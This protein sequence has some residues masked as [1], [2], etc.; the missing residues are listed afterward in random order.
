MYLL[1][2]RSIFF[3]SL[4]LTCLL[5]FNIN[6]KKSKITEKSLDSFDALRGWNIIKPEE[7]ELKLSITTGFKQNS[8]CLDYDLGEKKLYVVISKGMSIT[9]PQNYAFTFYIKGISQRN[10][11]EFKLVDKNDNTYLKKLNN[12]KFKKDWE[13][14]V[15]K[16]DDISFG[17]GPNPKLK[18]K[19]IKRIEFAISYK[20]GVKGKIYFDELSLVHLPPN[21]DTKQN[22]MK[23]ISSSI[24][25]S[26]NWCRPHNA[27]DGDL[28]TRWS[29]QFSDPQWLEIDIGV[30]RNISGLV[31]NW[32]Q[33]YAKAYDIY[34][35]LDRKKWKKVYEIDN[36]NGGIDEIYFK[37]TK[38]RFIKIFGRKR[39]TEYGYSLWEVSIKQ[40]DEI[41]VVTASSMQKSNRAE[42]I[43]DGNIE[44][45]W[46]SMIGGTQWVTIDFQG[47][48]EFSE[49]AIFWDKDYARTY[50]IQTSNDER[51]WD[52]AYIVDQGKGGTD[53]VYLRSNHAQ[54]IKIIC[55]KSNTRNGYG[56]KEI[57]IKPVSKEDVIPL[58]QYYEIVASQS[59]EGYYPRWLTKEQVFW[60]SIGVSNDEKEFILCEDGTIEPH[61]RG[62]IIMP[63]LYLDGKLITRNEARITQSL[64]NKYLP[65]PS[66][67][68]DYQDVVLNL[69]MFAYGKLRRSIA[70]AW[71]TIKN[72]RSTRVNGKL[73]LAIRAFQLYPPWQGGGGISPIYSIKYKDYIINVND[74]YKIYPLSKPDNFSVKSV[75]ID[76]PYPPEGDIISFI[77]QG[78]LSKNSNVN[79][80]H[81]NA[82]AG[83]EFSYNLSPGESKNFFIA[84]PLYDKKPD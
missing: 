38:A 5:F 74:K 48:K 39:K 29:S 66:V 82:S 32:E 62:F 72:N 57:E 41:P 60:T 37:E 24:Q 50:E 26:D 31:L 58:Q 33:A 47:I 22:N 1:K 84:I 65:I 36:G 27:V 25:A 67:K 45:K 46:H 76:T 13:K 42:N 52:T 77:K 75:D 54:F 73:F 23:A 35:S 12:Y 55:K 28:S 70:Y 68:W 80:N 4:A 3:L 51:I 8:L 20:A 16:K 79:V 14:L 30:E 2:K 9:L 21:M 49:L 59:P 10:D 53:R 83:I 61:K 7:T 56:I 19:E 69:K 15:F 40:P 43:L 18:L 34:L 78:A 81:G 63:F 11:F 71:Y 6:A 17:W 64:E 44:K